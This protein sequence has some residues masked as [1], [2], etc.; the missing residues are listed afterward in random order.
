MNKK[1]IL[2]IASPIV[3]ALIVF[4]LVYFEPQALLVDKKSSETQ[5]GQI[6]SK[7]QPPT[8]NETDESS[9]VVEEETAAPAKSQWISR[10]HQTTG[11][12]FLTADEN[13]N[14]YVRFENL[15]TDNGPDLKVYIAKSMSSDNSPIDFI[16]L[17]E[18]KANKGDAN[19]L[20]PADVNIEE[21]NHV[22]IWCKRFSSNFADAV[23]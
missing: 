18:L 20:I 11:E 1:K 5:Q 2:L 9:E 22:V 10:D 16:D 14:R 15:A 23:I 4:V 19:Y 12:V 6:I 13:G 8:S 21:Y 7:T 17:G 3:V